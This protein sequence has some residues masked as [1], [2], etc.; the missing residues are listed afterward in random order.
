MSL[1]EQL[2]DSYVNW[3]KQKITFKELDNAVEITTP[4]MDRH[5]DYLQIYVQQKGTKLIVSDAG[6][7]LTDLKLSGCDVF[8]SPKRKKIFQTILNGYGVKVSS[9]EELFVE[10]TVE[11]F[12]QKKHMLVQSMMTVNDMFM[13]SRENVHSIFLEEVDQFLFDN[14]I[15]FVDNINFTGKSGFPQTFHFAIPR[16]KQFPERILHAINNPTKQNSE[17]LLFAWTETKE[18][19]RPDSTL[20]AVLND[21]EKPIRPGIVNAFNEYEVQPILWSK[22]NEYI[23]HL[24]G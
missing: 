12:P 16:S 22:R 9:R 3:L 14:D 2:S 20:F 8:S 19:R 18:N 13:T 21:S 10:T 4:F 15:R 24:T 11:N 23:N 6:Y 17:T 1:V 5:N 7:I